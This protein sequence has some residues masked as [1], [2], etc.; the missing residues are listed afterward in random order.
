MEQG[1]E[2]PLTNRAKRLVT[3]GI[4]RVLGI[5]RTLLVDNIWFFLLV[6]SLTLY[7]HCIC[8][9][10]IALASLQYLALHCCKN[11]GCVQYQTNSCH[12]QAS[13]PPPP[14]MD[15]RE[16]TAQERGK[17]L[18]QMTLDKQKPLNSV[19]HSCT[20]CWSMLRRKADRRRRTS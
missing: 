1:V 12:L 20:I 13:P 14:V 5:A 19:G 10:T 17:Y 3:E 15:A 16:V 4:T 11:T 6:L 9:V 18:S 7:W 8:I 2:R